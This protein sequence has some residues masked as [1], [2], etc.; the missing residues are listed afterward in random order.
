MPLIKTPTAERFFAL[1]ATDSGRRAFLGD[2]EK[3]P[4]GASGTL[5]QLHR[6][7]ADSL[8]RARNLEQDRSR[9]PA[10]AHSAGRKLANAT[11]AKISETREALTDWV[12]KERDEAM[13][14]IGKALKPDIGTASQIVRA[15]IR[16]FVRTSLT[17]DKAAEFLVEL[18]DLIAADKQ[19]IEAI[20]EAPAKLSGLTPDR[21][22]RLRMDAAIAH[23]P[24]AAMRVKVAE[25][26]AALDEKL[27]SV[28]AEVPRVFFDPIVE[29]GMQTRVD[30][31]S[32]LR[33]E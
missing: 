29:A 28:A 2:W 23:A 16:N 17:G 4:P 12:A 14:E 11:V 15:D 5:L 30:V 19:W 10:Q 33:T 21:V 26:V 18:P 24:D 13:A 20:C 32:A 27:A 1:M 22:E 8:L 3:L 6:A 7:F 9:T 25:D 31:D